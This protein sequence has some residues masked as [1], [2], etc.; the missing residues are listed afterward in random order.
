MSA[1]QGINVL[2]DELLCSILDFVHQRSESSNDLFNVLM[3]SRRFHNLVLDILY[4]SPRLLKPNDTDV[5]SWHSRRAH[6]IHRLLSALVERPDLAKRIQH[7]DLTVVSDRPS[8]REWRHPNDI[9]EIDSSPY[10]YWPDYNEHRKILD[11]SYESAEIKRLDH[12]VKGWHYQVRTGFE[13]AIAGLILALTPSLKHLAVQSYRMCDDVLP[14]MMDDF[15]EATVLP[16]LEVDSINPTD[17]FGGYASR[18]TRVPAGLANLVSIKCNGLIS[19]PI[20]RLSSLISI[21]TGL[22]DVRHSKQLKLARTKTS[23]TTISNVLR[24]AVTMDCV[25]LVIDGQY[26]RDRIYL[27]WFTRYMRQLNTLRINFV[28]PD[29]SCGPDYSAL[30]RLIHAPGLHTLI[31][32][33]QNIT[34]TRETTSSRALLPELSLL[35]FPE[36]KRIVAPQEALFQD[37]SER[38]CQLPASI[39]AMEI[40]EPTEALSDCLAKMMETG[41]HLENLKSITIWRVQNLDQPQTLHTLSA[42]VCDWIDE[43]MINFRQRLLVED[44]WS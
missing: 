17:W 43:R 31:L 2:P 35:Q 27:K 18:K 44:F 25:P 33:T 6:Q 30:L 22:S 26:F 12:L 14:H 9:H 13:P 24:L 37:G 42:R 4:R 34:R 23:K 8:G 1:N 5:A 19:W 40:C 3:V 41:D 7:L 38:S 11:I 10:Y 29:M 36:L 20:L 39:E 21:E 15:S 32:D 16:R 28:G